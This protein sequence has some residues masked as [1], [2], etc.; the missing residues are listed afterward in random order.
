MKIGHKNCRSLKSD[1]HVEELEVELEESVNDWAAIL[2]NE[3]WREQAEEYD[4]LESDHIW[5]GSGGAKGQHGVG[6]LL[7]RR[8]AQCV[9]GWRAIN[10]RIGVLELDTPE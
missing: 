2:L 4:T 6:I 10:Q 7:H 5:F 9:R 3:T 8:W 1:D